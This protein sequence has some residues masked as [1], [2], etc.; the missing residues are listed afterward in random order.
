MSADKTYTCK[1]TFFLQ[2]SYHTGSSG[3]IDIDIS[4]N[5]NVDFICKFMI[6]IITYST[7]RVF[8]LFNDDE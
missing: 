2:Y 5:V 1:V 4:K 3:V 7:T 8:C 6:C